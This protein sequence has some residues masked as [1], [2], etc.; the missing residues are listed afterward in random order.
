M[1]FFKQ[2][3]KA[4]Q[5]FNEAN[6]TDIAEDFAENTNKIVTDSYLQDAWVNIAID[7]LMRN[8][9]RAKYVIRKDK[10]IVE[11][12]PVA[13]LFKEPNET[14]TCFD[15]W[16][17]TTGWWF[18]EG[19]AFWYFG[20]DYVCG[21]PKEI[22]VLNPRFLHHEVINGKIIKWFYSGDTGDIPFSILPDELIHFRNWNPWN[23]YRG[24]N[25]L[26]SLSMEVEQDV[27]ACKANSDLLREGGI[28]KGLL[29]TD[30]I[31]REEEADQLE[32]R[33][34][35]KYGKGNQRKVAVIGKG[36]SYQ[37]LTFSPTALRLFDLKRWNLYTVLA[38]FGIPPRVANM[39]E[40]NSSLSG[41]DTESQHA[42]FWK[43]TLVP[44]LKN[45]EQIT[46]VQLFRRFKLSERG[47]F[48]LSDIPELQESEDA[49]SKR[50]IE[51]VNNGLQTINDILQKR[52]LETK[53]WGDVWWRPTNVIKCDD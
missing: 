21:I 23:K 19:E 40:N 22:I 9:G 33:W 46:E 50:D 29:K 32:K 44:L 11:D 51:E 8:I 6:D 53:P 48:D 7:I 16:K 39:Q 15:L 18:L 12:T 26:V 38:K 47:C 45:F 14:L 24:V 10:K 2:V 20:A 13:Q 3:R 42:A 41:T 37:Q 1:K 35:S 5:T 34:E 31:V 27:L 17:Q 4:L 25:P 30:Q 36:T 52:G 43:Y 28:P 49:Q